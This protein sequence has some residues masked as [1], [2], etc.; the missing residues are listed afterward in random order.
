VRLTQ[1]GRAGARGRPATRRRRTRATTSRAS[2]GVRRRRRREAEREEFDREAL[3]AKIRRSVIGDDVVLDGPFGP[4]R[5]V[6][7][8]YTA[9]GRSLSFIEDFMRHE[10]MPFYAN[11]HSESSGTGAQ[12]SRLREDA[13]AI[14]HRGGR[15][16]GRT[17][18]CCS[19]A[20][21]R[22]GRS[23]S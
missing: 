18:W 8:D 5:L 15:T 9:S 6:Y 4:R 3:I 19:S 12:T 14:I 11:T 13:R 20:R 23:T 7:A 22:R 2:R 10:V 1:D 21:G 16:A 17:T